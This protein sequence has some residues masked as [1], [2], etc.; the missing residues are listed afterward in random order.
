[1]MDGMFRMAW[2]HMR[3]LWSTSF[4]L[5]TAVVSPLSFALLRLIAARWAAAPSL[6]LDAAVCGLW[7][8]TTLAVGLIG[9][10]RYQGVL[11]YLT[12]SPLPLWRVFAPLVAAATLIGVIGLP[13]SFAVIVVAGL[14]SGHDPVPFGVQSIG[15]QLIGYLLAV[16][17]C[18][19]SAMLLSSIFVLSRSAIAF[20]PLVLIPVWMLCGIVMPIGLFPPF[21]RVVALLH[22]LTWAVWIGQQRSFDPLCAWAAAGCLSLCGAYLAAAGKGLHVALRRACVEGTLDLS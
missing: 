8:T 6:W 19:A 11:K 4:F 17:A 13:I 10:Q 15:L 20:E 3:N 18:C 16:V 2:F 14:L 1:M 7:S 5:E 9:F 21:L 12:V 22:P